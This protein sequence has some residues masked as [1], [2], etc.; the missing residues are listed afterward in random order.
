MPWCHFVPPIAISKKHTSLAL[1]HFL[2]PIAPC[3]CVRASMLLAYVNY[4]SGHITSRDPS[5]L[6]STCSH[7]QLYLTPKKIGTHFKLGSFKRRA[8][9]FLIVL[10]TLHRDSKDNEIQYDVRTQTENWSK[11]RKI[12]QWPSCWYAN[13]AT[14]PRLRYLQ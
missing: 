3:P 2:S 10:R 11:G 8:R 5:W 6:N 14:A 13:P 4:R 1:G 12:R 7:R 9:L